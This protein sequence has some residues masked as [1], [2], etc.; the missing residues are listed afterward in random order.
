[1]PIDLNALRT[2]YVRTDG[3]T[4]PPDNTSQDR[5][6]AA[7]REAFSAGWAS[8]QA[9]EFGVGPHLDQ[10]EAFAEYLRHMLAVWEHQPG[11]S[12]F[13]DTPPYNAGDPATWRQR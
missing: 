2:E 4:H 6:V 1:M 10:D 7:L 8:H 9:L 5:I 12:P 13:A 3:V 11:R